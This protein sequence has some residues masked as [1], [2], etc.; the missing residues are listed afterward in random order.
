MVIAGHVPYCCLWPVYARSDAAPSLCMS[1]A[2]LAALVFVKIE[3]EMIKIT[4]LSLT[5]TQKKKKLN[6]KP[7]TTGAG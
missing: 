7:D 5:I 3:R 6:N 4:Y 2:M 1:W